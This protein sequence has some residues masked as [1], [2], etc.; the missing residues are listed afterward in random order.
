M[1]LIVGAGPV[2]LTLAC[3]LAACGVEARL[4]DQRAGRVA[5]SR[6]TDVHART[7]EL[8]ASL[9]LAEALIARGEPARGASFYARGEAIAEFETHDLASP[10]PLILGVPQ[11]ETEALLEEHLEASGRRVEREVRLESFTQGEG[12]VQAQ[13]RDAAGRLEVV[14]ASWLVGCDGAH[15]TVRGLL[16]V[17]FEGLSYEEP[18]LLADVAIRWALPKDRLHLFF[19]PEGFF[20]ALPMPGEGRTRLFVDEGAMAGAPPTLETF[21]AMASARVHVPAQLEAPGW[22]SRFRVHRRMVSRYQHGRVFLAGD[23]AHIHSPVGG[24]GMNMGIQDAFNLGWK[25]AAVARGEASP[26]LLASYE[27][28]RHPIAAS[29]LLKTH[30]AT[31]MSTARHPWAQ[32]VRDRTSGWLMGLPGVQQWVAGMTAAL[33]YDLRESPLV[34]AAQGSLWAAAAHRRSAEDEAPGMREWLEFAAGPHPGDRVPS[35]WFGA[36]DDRRHAHS[37]VEPRRHRVLLFDGAAATEGGYHRLREIASALEA[38]LG[39]AVEAWIVVPQPERPAELEGF[40]RVVLDPAGELHCSFGARA[41]CAYTL[42]PDGYIGFRAQP[43]TL[44]VLERALVEVTGLG[45]LG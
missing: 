2:G 39:A 12:G 21:Q 11:H 1:I 4:I 22:M 45:W 9:G 16:G 41:E 42:R 35:R 36:E 13:L 8:L 44:E 24:Q 37:L 38:Q 26:R 18:F 40:A 20:M 17:A 32:A 33:E 5:E 7:L 25:L 23:A 10:F 14:E 28:E 43:V 19:S 34:A 31:R 6:A 29:V 27:A 15:S 3:V 30:M